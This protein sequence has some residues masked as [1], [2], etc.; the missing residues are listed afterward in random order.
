VEN[1]ILLASDLRERGYRRLRSSAFI[2]AGR[3]A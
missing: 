3:R 2:R 1:S